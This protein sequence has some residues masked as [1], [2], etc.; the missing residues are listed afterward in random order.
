M[1]LYKRIYIGAY[2][3]HSQVEGEINI[4]V[5]GKKVPVNFKKV[6]NI[7]EE[8]AYWRK[9]N[10]IHNWFVQNLAAGVD[11]CRPVFCTIDD[12]RKLVKVCERILSAPE[13]DRQRVAS[14]ILPTQQGFFFG[15]TDYDQYYYDDLKSTIDMLNE[16]IASHDDTVSVYYEY[17][18]SW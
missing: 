18:A 2:W 9:A 3:E 12:L 4:F 7:V 15:S 16:V 10:A 14:N 13:S 6:A 11:D 5:K 17:R 1:F 8:A